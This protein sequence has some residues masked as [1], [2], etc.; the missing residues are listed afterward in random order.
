MCGRL[1]CQLTWR[2]IHDQLSAWCVGLTAETLARPDP[3]TSYNV[4]PTQAVAVLRAAQTDERKDALDGAML[5]WWLLPFWSK[6]STITYPTF[7]ARS[8][9]VAGKPAFRE[10]FRERRCVVPVN[11]FYEW[12]KRDDGTKQPYYVTR[13]DGQP[14]FFAG[15]WDRWVSPGGEGTIESCTVLT[16]SPNAEMASIH[17]RMPCVLEPEAVAGWVDPT[18]R[19]PERVGAFLRPAADGVL[20]KR[21]VSTRVNNARNDGPDLLGPADLGLFGE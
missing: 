21:A 12:C 18:T 10:P 3:P 19:D 17:H 20:Q 8:E 6:A 9:D 11:G 15:L 1:S 7:N 4:A 14:T 13:A 5:R 2:Q 16:T